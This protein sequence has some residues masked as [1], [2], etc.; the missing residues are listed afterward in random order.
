M[1]CPLTGEPWIVQEPPLLK[2]I[3]SGLGA[4]NEDDGTIP[5][6]TLVHLGG[7]A[8]ARSITLIYTGS[9]FHDFETPRLEVFRQ[10]PL[11]I[12]EWS[13]RFLPP[14]A[15]SLVADPGA[16]PVASVGDAVALLLL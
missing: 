1:N 10:L 6:F 16:A 8:A 14:P 4:A 3:V 11:A 2:G 9:G 13:D 5:T 12:L 7:V 15:V